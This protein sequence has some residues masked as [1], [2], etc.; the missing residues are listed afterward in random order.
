MNPKRNRFNS[1]EVIADQ[2]DLP[3]TL[4]SRFDL[5]FAIRDVVNLE[6]DRK[7]CD[8]IIR[9]RT[10]KTVQTDYAPEDITKYIIYVRSKISSMDP[11][12]EEAS[13]L[14][15]D[16]FLEIRTSNKDGTVPITFRQMDGMMRLAE[17]CAKLRLS[18]IVEKQDAEVALTIVKHYMDT[19]CMDT[20][21]HQYNADMVI[22]GETKNERKARIGLIGFVEDNLD[23]LT[24]NEENGWIDTKVLEK[25][26]MDRMNVSQK[27]FDKALKEADYENLLKQKKGGTKLEY[28]GEKKRSDALHDKY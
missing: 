26:F 23:M 24:E 18:R 8:T 20:S 25:A 1:E 28:R 19:M 17:A 15:K 12:T 9:A 3:P 13:N 14:L 4:L 11:P 6:E 5:I 2:I 16:R 27:E 22:G 7:K 10:G 21:S